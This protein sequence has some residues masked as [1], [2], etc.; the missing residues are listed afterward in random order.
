MFCSRSMGVHLLRGGAVL[1]MR[2]C[3]AC[4]LMG[5]V[6]TWQQKDGTSQDPGR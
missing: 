4:W 3:P 6:E 1:L 2:G 5:L